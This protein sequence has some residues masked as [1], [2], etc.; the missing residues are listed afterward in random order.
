MQSMVI[1][2]EEMVDL[3]RNYSNARSRALSKA[4]NPNPGTLSGCATPKLTALNSNS[5]KH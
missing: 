4:D 2:K 3:H 1:L 5:P